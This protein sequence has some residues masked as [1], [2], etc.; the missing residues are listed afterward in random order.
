MN[1][2]STADFSMRY[3]IVFII[4]ADLHNFII[5]KKSKYSMQKR[6]N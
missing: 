6:D 5:N 1:C 2:G 4:D 3:G